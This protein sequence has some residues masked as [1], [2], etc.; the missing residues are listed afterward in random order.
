M[1]Q[2]RDGLQVALATR[3][4]IGQAKGVLMEREGFTDEGAFQ[5]LRK[6]SQHTN[7]KLHKIAQEVV[8]STQ[9]R[10]PP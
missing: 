2:D 4:I 10:N 1:R 3:D 5:M 8:A 7:T 9:K 6:A